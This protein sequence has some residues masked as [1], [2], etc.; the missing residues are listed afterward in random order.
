M[1][2]FLEL[3]I[4]ATSF[5]NSISR[6]R[7]YRN[8]FEFANTAGDMYLWIFCIVAFPFMFGA[9]AIMNSITALLALPV[10]VS[11][12][13]AIKYSVKRKRPFHVIP[14]IVKFGHILDK[15][16]FPSGHTLHAVLFTV[17]LSYQLGL[18][19]AVPLF[20]LTTLIV[21]SRPGLGIHYVSDVIVGAAIGLVISTFALNFVHPNS[22]Q[23]LAY[24][25]NIKL[26]FYA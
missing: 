2:R 9:Q 20:L 4:K 8:V 15:Y 25:N 6:N 24:I 10:S 13:S 12:Q 16:S 26:Y 17:I 1:K 3:D 21:L 19:V 7:A 22:E 14:E 23:I 5:I 18:V 11:I